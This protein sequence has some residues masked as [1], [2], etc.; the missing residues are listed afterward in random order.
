[1]LDQ[2]ITDHGSIETFLETRLRLDP[3]VWVALRSTI[4]VA[5]ASVP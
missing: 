4:L 1:M 2:I 5:N 3:E